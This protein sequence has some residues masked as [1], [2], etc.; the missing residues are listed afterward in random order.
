M[1]VIVVLYKVCLATKFTRLG[2][3]VQWLSTF[4]PPYFSSKKREIVRVHG[5]KVDRGP[6]RPD[7]FSLLNF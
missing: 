5:R 1:G 3:K 7:V 2:L 6:D 4:F